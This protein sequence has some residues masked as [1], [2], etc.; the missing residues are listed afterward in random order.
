MNRRLNNH[1]RQFNSN[2]FSLASITKNLK[3]FLIN[4]EEN[5]AAVLPDERLFNNFPT[6]MSKVKKRTEDIVRLPMIRQTAL[7]FE[8]I[9]NPTI[10]DLQE[11]LLQLKKMAKNSPYIREYIAM[12]QN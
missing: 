10:Y 9:N 7:D 3:E 5:Q 11:T 4:E 6:K 1:I 2:K 12:L 8:E